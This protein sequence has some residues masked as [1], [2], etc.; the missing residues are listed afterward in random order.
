M[1][2]IFLD[3][4]SDDGLPGDWRRKVEHQLEEDGNSH[5]RGVGWGARE[6]ET[7]PRLQ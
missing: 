4:G 5:E 6:A 7:F 1:G 2:S 3:C